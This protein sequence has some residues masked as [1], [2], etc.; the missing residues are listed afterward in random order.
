MELKTLFRKRKKLRI[1][2][3]AGTQRCWRRLQISCSTPRQGCWVTFPLLMILKIFFL[4]I[5]EKFGQVL[6]IL[7]I[8]MKKNNFQPCSNMTAL[9]T[10]KNSNRGIYLNTSKKICFFQFHAN[11]DLQMPH[12]WW[13]LQIVIIFLNPFRTLKS[14]PAFSIFFVGHPKTMAIVICIVF[15]DMFF[16]PFEVYTFPRLNSIATKRKA[17]QCSKNIAHSKA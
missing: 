8:C 10:K 7:E 12:L 4:T 9:P 6:T 3:Q 14:Y 1:N 17:I 13:D 2:L 15:C 11:W 5:F 16:W